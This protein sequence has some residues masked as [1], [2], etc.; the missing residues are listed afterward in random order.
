MPL[1]FKK[2]A[3]ARVASWSKTSRRSGP[4]DSV[5]GVRRYRGEFRGSGIRAAMA[6]VDKL[7]EVARSHG[8][9]AGQAAL[10]W[11]SRKPE[12]VAIPGA[13]SAKQAADNAA[14]VGWAMSDDEA[15]AIDGASLAWRRGG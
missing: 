10:N 15:E 11:I 2:T 14:A 9:T 3:Y 5:N 6:V 4:G 1:V 8:A 13:K 12:V 7:E